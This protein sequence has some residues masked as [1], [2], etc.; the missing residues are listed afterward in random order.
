MYHIIEKNLYNLWLKSINLILNKGNTIEDDK[1]NILEVLN[2][3]LQT[4]NL[5]LLS[6]HYEIWNNSSYSSISKSQNMFDYNERVQ[7]FND[8]NQIKKIIQRLQ[9]ARYSKAA[10]VV[11]LFPEHD[12]SKIPCLISI[13]FKIRNNQLNTTAFFR[14]QDVWKKQLNNF[15]LLVSLIQLIC[16]SVN[17]KPGNLSLLIA[18]AHI[19]NSD[20]KNISKLIK[21]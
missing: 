11:T 21:I 16:T 18:S 1:E 15:T 13:D 9:K 6:N 12:I 3:F 14:S 8:T 5:E 7:N 20:L 4:D 2:L 17:T 10:T 19:Y